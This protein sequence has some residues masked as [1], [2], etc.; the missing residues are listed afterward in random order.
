[1]KFEHVPARPGPKA[2]HLWVMLPG[3]Y[4]KPDD[5]L[6]AGFADAIHARGLPHDIALL[7]ATISEVVDGSALLLLQDYLRAIAPTP[8]RKVCLLGISLGAQL[9]MLCL[10]RGGADAPQSQAAARVSHAFVLAPY[11]GPR[12][13]LAK[14]AAGAGLAD[15]VLPPTGPVDTESEIWHWLQDS[16]VRKPPLYL[17]YGSDDRFAG[18]HAMM[19]RT[20]PEERVDRQPGGHD[21]PV[22]S[23]LWNRHLDLF[24]AR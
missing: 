11:L 19:A 17:G 4:M 1:M 14:M 20:L 10:A 9:A 2:T 21:W 24:H 6:C 12:D 13:L 23:A 7:E 18:G 3:A 22:W 16:A 5:F 8:A 15:G